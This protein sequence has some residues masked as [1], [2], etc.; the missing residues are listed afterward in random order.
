[1]FYTA[2]VV[3]NT[4]DKLDDRIYVYIPK[5]MPLMEPVSKTSETKTVTVNGSSIEVNLENTVI[6]NPFNFNN[7]STNGKRLVPEVG[8]AVSVFFLDNDYSQCY[9]MDGSSPTIDGDSLRLDY[10]D[11]MEDKNNHSLDPLLKPQQKVLYK[12][13]QNTILAIDD[14]DDS[15][16]F[17]LKVNNHHKLKIEH[18]NDNDEIRLFTGGGH[19][20]ILDDHVDRP[21]IS[22]TTATGH[23]M[24]MDDHADRPGISLTTNGGHSAILD[25]LSTTKKVQ[26]TTNSGHNVLMNDVLGDEK[27]YLT[28]NGGHGVLMDDVNTEIKADA[29][30]GDNM[31]IGNDIVKLVNN[32]GTI[33]TGNGSKAEV[34]SAAGDVATLDSGTIVATAST[35]GG[36]TIGGGSVSIN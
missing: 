23:K 12:S 9:Y 20:V 33:L 22:A 5:L 29:S 27:I 36:I 21:S 4:D 19:E 24:L 13:K 2:I 30:T 25:D 35:G 6:S 16:S 11:N 31:T 10:A 26:I 17:I 3:S 1:M 8:D 15:F 18:N 32:S 14:N 7:S 34:K 28:T